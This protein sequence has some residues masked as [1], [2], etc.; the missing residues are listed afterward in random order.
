MGAEMVIRDRLGAAAGG[1]DVIL[2]IGV[3]GARQVRGGIRAAQAIYILPPSRDTLESR[4]QGRKQDGAEVIGERMRQAVSEMSHWD[5]S[6]YLVVNDRFEV[7]LADLQAILRANRLRRPA[8]G[9]RLSGLIRELL[10]AS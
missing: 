6:D 4:L 3:Q 2:E 9:T 5:E 7:A 8:Q 10:S 1:N